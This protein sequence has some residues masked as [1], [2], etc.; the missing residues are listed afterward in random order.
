[1]RH[2]KPVRLETAPTVLPLGSPP[3]SPRLLSSLLAG[4]TKGGADTVR[5]ETEP[6]V[7]PFGRHCFQ[8]CRYGTV[9]N[10]TYRP[11]VG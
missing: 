4:G 7:V 10:R 8:L 6:T 5:L 2:S 9:R 11:P 3:I 1:M